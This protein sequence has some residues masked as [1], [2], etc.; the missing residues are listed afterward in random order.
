MGIRQSVMQII[1][2]CLDFESRAKCATLS[3]AFAGLDSSASRSVFARKE[4]PGDKESERGHARH[5]PIDKREEREER[6]RRRATLFRPT[7]EKWRQ[8]FFLLGT[9]TRFL[10]QS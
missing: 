3:L 5:A 10:H 2:F 7:S 8:L 9:E 6:R 1:V 4:R